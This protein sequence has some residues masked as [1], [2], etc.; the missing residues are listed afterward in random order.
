METIKQHLIKKALG[1][2]KKIFPC[3]GKQNLEECFTIEGKRI[4][5]WF[6]TEDQNTHTIS[7]SI[8]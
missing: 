5:F 1:T 6:N 4:I 3:T 7:T 8:N 2:H